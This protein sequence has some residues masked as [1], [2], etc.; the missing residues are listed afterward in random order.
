MKSKQNRA[1]S[2][3]PIWIGNPE[4]KQRDLMEYTRLHQICLRR[5]R[6]LRGYITKLNSYLVRLDLDNTIRKPLKT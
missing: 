1:K 6:G 3:V 2:K 5:F 4:N